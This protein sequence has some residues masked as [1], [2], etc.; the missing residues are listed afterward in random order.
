MNWHAIVWVHLLIRACVYD[1]H[2]QN[3]DASMQEGLTA[4]SLEPA[5]RRVLSDVEELRCDV[6][7]LRPTK[8]E[9]PG[10]T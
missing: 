3:F 4:L 2:P 1:F 5:A 8:T 6:S 9:I 10:T 7:V